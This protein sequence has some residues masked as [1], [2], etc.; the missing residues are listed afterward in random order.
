MLSKRDLKYYASLKQKKYRSSE[1][2]FIAEGVRLV[3]EGIAG[4]L[5]CELVIATEEF[6]ESRK[7]FL[8]AVKA[9]P[10]TTEILPEKD[11]M[12]LSDTLHPQGVIGVFHKPEEKCNELTELPDSIVLLD[13]ISD[14]GNVGTIIR[15]CDWFGITMLSASSGSADLYNPKVV[16]SAM[17]GHF[18]I[19]LFEADSI[20]TIEYLKSRG[21]QIIASDTEGISIFEFTKPAKAAYI[22]SSEAAGLSKPLLPLI[23]AKTSIPGRGKAESLNV[24]SAAAIIIA[25]IMQ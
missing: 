5:Y 24:A 11:F 14:P 2:K 21:Y 10:V 22:F 12:N 9:Q 23:D 6:A 13:D 19:K 16:R 7:D 1:G 15:T 17:G 8:D 4:Q 25:Q 20:G 3:E 18:H